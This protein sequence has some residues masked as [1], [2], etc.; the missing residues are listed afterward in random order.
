MVKEVVGITIRKQNVAFSNEH[1]YALA[2]KA[3]KQQV[4]VFLIQKFLG[5]RKRKDY[6][7]TGK[8]LYPNCL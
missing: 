6:L 5:K 2:R 4:Y 1:M 8:S 7:V 3:P